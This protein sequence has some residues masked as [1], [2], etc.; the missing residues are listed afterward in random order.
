MNRCYHPQIDFSD[1]VFPTLQGKEVSAMWHMLI[2]RGKDT[3][4][5]FHDIKADESSGICYW[6]ATYSY[7]SQKNKVHNI[8]TSRFEFLDGLI[9]KQVDS[10][11]LTKWLGMAM[12]AI[13]LLLGWSGFLKK[14]V[15]KMADQN[16]RDFIKL[17]SEYSSI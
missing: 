5:T 1:P 17:N 12:G 10:F 11:N 13:G 6:E 9:I 16:L 2:T 15:R 14:K 4:I 3:V 7:G 8:V